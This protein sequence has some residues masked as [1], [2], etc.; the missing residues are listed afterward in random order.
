MKCCPELAWSE[1]RKAWAAEVVVA[2]AARRTAI[3]TIHLTIDTALIDTGIPPYIPSNII[4]RNVARNGHCAP[5]GAGG[6][7][8]EDGQDVAGGVLEPGDV[9]A[10]AAHDALGVVDPVVLLELDAAC[11][12]LVDGRLDVV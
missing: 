3:T 12:E 9:W 6:L 11:D 8:G 5:V 7:H 4:G 10:L 1:A 2:V